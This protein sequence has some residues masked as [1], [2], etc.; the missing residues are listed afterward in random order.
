MTD[1]TLASTKEWLTLSSNK[2]NRHEST[3][4]YY[5]EVGHYL[6]R[7]NETDGVIEKV[8]KHIWNF[9]QGSLTQ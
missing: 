6:L 4:T 2:A 5:I 7:R 9:R 1:P 8:E 3:N